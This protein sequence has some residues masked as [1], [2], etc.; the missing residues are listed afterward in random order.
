M[1][2]TRG[3]EAS[4]RRILKVNPLLVLLERQKRTPIAEPG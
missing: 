1:P 4:L 3:F 2:V